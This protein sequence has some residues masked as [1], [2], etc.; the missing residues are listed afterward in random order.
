MKENKNER[1]QETE[2]GREQGRKV[3]RKEGRQDAHLQVE[4]DAISD[5]NPSFIRSPPQPKRHVLTTEAH[6]AAWTTSPAP[7]KGLK[8]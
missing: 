1:K 2:A 8:L 3:A 5:S 4:L 7:R 6:R